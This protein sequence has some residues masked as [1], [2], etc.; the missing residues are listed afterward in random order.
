MLVVEAGLTGLCPGRQGVRL[1]LPLSLS[2][3]SSCCL[4]FPSPTLIRGCEVA[5]RFI[6]CAAGNGALS[7]SVAF[8]VCC[9]FAFNPVPPPCLGFSATPR[10]TS[11]LESFAVLTSRPSVH[12]LWASALRTAHI[13]IGALSLPSPSRRRTK[14]TIRTLLLLVLLDSLV[15][16]FPHLCSLSL[17]LRL[18]FR[19]TSWLFLFFP[20]LLPSLAFS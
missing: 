3:A 10:S 4:P 5:A 13:G 6:V 14:T 7:F 20:L 8:V 2:R 17:S 19:P 15:L 16:F 9:S 1:D 11:C 18:S 12:A